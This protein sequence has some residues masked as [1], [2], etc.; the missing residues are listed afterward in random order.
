MTITEALQLIKQVGFTAHPVPGTTSYMI[1]SPAGQVTWMKEQ[2]L[3]QLVR[4]L[5]KNPHQ[6][7]TVLSQMV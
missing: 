3:L 6:L 7:K 4:S 5:K 2:V 1:E